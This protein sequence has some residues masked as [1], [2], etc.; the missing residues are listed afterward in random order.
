MLKTLLPP[1]C[2]TEQSWFDLERE[3]LFGQ[4]WL[5]A[6]FT[7]QLV[8]DNS[9]I[10]RRLNGVPVLLQNCNGQIK[11]FRNACAHRGMPIQTE[12]C[13]RRKMI[14][15]YHGWGYDS[16]GALRGVPNGTM[17]GM[18]HAEKDAIRLQAFA[19]VTVGMFVFVNLSA[20]PM[21]IGEQYTSEALRIL[22]V[23][24]SGAATQMS[25]T[26]FSKHYNWKLNFENVVDGHH[27]QFIHPQ[28][29]A[30]LLD[31][32]SSGVFAPAISETSTWF[33]PGGPL[34]D[35]DLPVMFPTRI[36]TKLQD[37]SVIARSS[38]QYEPRW[39]S[40]LVNG[41]DTGSILNL[42]LYPNLNVGS[43]HG[44]TFFVQQFCPM[45]ADVT[46]IHSWV[47]TAELKPGVPAQ[48]Q[49][50]W[51]MHHAEMNVIEEDAVLLAPLQ[52]ALTSAESVGWLG[53]HEAP[54]ASMG[55]WYMNHLKGTAEQ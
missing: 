14:C 2:Y 12:P 27:I 30:R 37:I 54:L 4:L 24:S 3:K 47:F 39:F 7:H 31:Y 32:Q 28:S 38:M 21:D 10:T 6:G 9:F 45:A 29:F 5:F 20:E 51:G 40:S 19:V 35:L 16:E 22:E 34:S 13:G 17:F 53:D 11:A 41:A 18:C 25:Y 23:I 44:E 46:E 36:A 43:L 42:R 52:Q 33:G 15:P 50:L 8:A 48:P 55:I 1:A 49:L 26:H